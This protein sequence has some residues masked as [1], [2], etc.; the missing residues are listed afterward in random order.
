MGS[1]Y[2]TLSVCLGGWDGYQAMSSL[3]SSKKH[4][5]GCSAMLCN[6][7]YDDLQPCPPSMAPRNGP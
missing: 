4:P 1:Q 6:M 7:L 5:Q 3:N 2:E